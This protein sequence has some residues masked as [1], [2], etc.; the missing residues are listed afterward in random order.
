M[1]KITTLVPVEADP[2]IY[3]VHTLSGTRYEIDLRVHGRWTMQRHPAPDAGPLWID[4]RTVFRHGLP[5]FTVGRTATMWLR[6]S[7]W[8]ADD[9]WAMCSTVISITKHD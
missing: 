3:S 8:M 5:A 4:E 7:G 2:G 9:L 6:G 1:D